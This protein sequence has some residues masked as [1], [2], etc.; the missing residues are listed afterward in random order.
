MEENGNGRISLHPNDA[1]AAGTTL[2][3]ALRAYPED[4]GESHVFSINP[5]YYL[6]P[7]ITNSLSLETK[8][9]IGKIVACAMDLGLSNLQEKLAEPLSTIQSARQD[10]I[11]HGGDWAEKEFAFNKLKADFH[12][13]KM[14]RWSVRMPEEPV[15]RSDRLATNTGV[16]SHH[17]RQL[18]ILGGLIHSVNISGNDQRKMVEVIRWWKGVLL[19]KAKVARDIQ[20]RRLLRPVVDNVPWREDPWEEIL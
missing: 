2:E 9:P 12:T 1:V 14:S 4:N 7:Q 10:V 3:E 20:K 8:Y 16:L 19:E 13:S 5:C 18:A 15:I 11:L 6:I 17:L